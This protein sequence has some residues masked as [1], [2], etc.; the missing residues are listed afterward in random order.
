[1]YENR[2]IPGYLT[3][4]FAITDGQVPDPQQTIALVASKVSHSRCFALG[5][6]YDVDRNLVEGIAKNG[7]GTAEFVV[8]NEIIEKKILHQLKISLRP[9]LLLPIRTSQA[10]ITRLL[11]Y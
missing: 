2:Q 7:A 9:A 5:I 1:V 3:Q 4:I 6:G 11:D 8:E 10:K